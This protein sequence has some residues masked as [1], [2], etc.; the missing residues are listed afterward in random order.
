MHLYIA[1][2][3]FRGEWMHASNASSGFDAFSCKQAHAFE[4]H[5]AFARTHKHTHVYTECVMNFTLCV[6]KNAIE[7]FFHFFHSFSFFQFSWI[8]FIF[9]GRMATLRLD[10]FFQVDFFDECSN[11]QRRILATHF[12]ITMCFSGSR[13]QLHSSSSLSSLLLFTPHEFYSIQS[14]VRI[15]NFEFPILARIFRA[16]E[17][18]HEM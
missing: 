12:S 5:S 8:Y 7:P 18:I 15:L 3:A 9:V 13:M 6:S 1:A 4:D 17:N 11:L 2:F 10:L 16:F 14:L